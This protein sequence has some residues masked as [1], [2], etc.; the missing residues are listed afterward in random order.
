M[1]DQHPTPTC[2][3][4]PE[5]RSG[6]PR[7]RRIYI[8]WAIALTLL[9]STALFCWLV[10]VPVWQVKGVVEAFRKK[11]I[12]YGAKSH[13][14]EGLLALQALG[15]RRKS[16]SKLRLYTRMPDGVATHKAF[17]IYLMGLCGES[18][19]PEIMRVLEESE[20][21][22]SNER[23]LRQVAGLVALNEIGPPA[24]SLLAEM[25]AARCAKYG[26]LSFPDTLRALGPKAE[27]TLKILVRDEN[28]EVRQAAAEAL[29]KIKAAQEKK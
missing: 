13:R 24:S 20:S 6:K 2:P 27:P 16:L 17:A 23:E 14:P 25:L 28:P 18:A 10:V 15:G 5:G 8:L 3:A 19:L 1:M 7:S 29:K 11:A 4:E 22:D 12:A 26:N 9:I 21:A